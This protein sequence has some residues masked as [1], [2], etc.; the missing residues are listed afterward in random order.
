MRCERYYQL[1]RLPTNLFT[2]FSQTFANHDLCGTFLRSCSNCQRRDVSHGAFMRA[3]AAELLYYHPLLS[4]LAH[5][6]QDDRRLGIFP[7]LSA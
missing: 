1:Q 4:P 6:V 2:A 3:A 5:P 7:L